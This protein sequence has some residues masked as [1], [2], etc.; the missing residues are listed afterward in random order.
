MQFRL[1]T[2]NIHKGIGGVDRRYRPERI[3]ETLRRYKPDI[4]HLQEVTDGV[5][6]FHRHRQVDLIGDALDLEFRAYQPNVRLSH[7][8]Y[9]NAILSRFHLHELH[10]IDLKL[11]LKKRRRAQVARL[12]LNLDNGHTRSLILVNLHLGLAEFE[13]RIQLRRILESDHVKRAHHDTPMIVAGDL[14]DV[15]ARA[16]RQ[17]FAPNGFR[18]GCDTIKTFPAFMPFRALDQIHYRG[19]LELDRC[20]VCPTPLAAR[21]SDHLPLI[22]DFV[23]S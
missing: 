18:N 1:I 13:R 9:G 23:V 21:A 17:A 20:H 11:P 16:G 2:W 7:G 19:L 5:P 8:N 6:R 3:V 10:D 4:L 12:R 15:M 22:A 14:N